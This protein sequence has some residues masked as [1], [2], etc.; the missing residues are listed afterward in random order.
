MSKPG[1][2][3][4]RVISALCVLGSGV[5][6]IA[7]AQSSSSTPVALV[8]GASAA[9]AIN[10]RQQG[11]K[12][13][14]AAFKV[15]HKELSGPSPDAAKIAAAAAEI[16]ASTAVMGQWFPAGSGPQSGVK[17]QARAE[18]WTDASGFAATRAAYIRQVEKSARQLADPGERAA[19]KDS[20]AALGQACKDCHDSYRVKG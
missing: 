10:V 16:K 19:W 20:S 1:N 18:I 9:E 7:V 15:I 6:A 3:V 12:K 8:Q 5:A 11:F 17:T 2:V 14:G 4:V 13:L